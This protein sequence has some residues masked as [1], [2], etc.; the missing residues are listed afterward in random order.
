VRAGLDLRRVEAV[1]LT[2]APDKLRTLEGQ[3]SDIIR[4]TLYSVYTRAPSAIFTCASPPAPAPRRS[5][6]RVS[7]EYTAGAR[8]FGV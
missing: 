8:G 2:V 5:V 7:R 4:R 1:V 3:H 6:S